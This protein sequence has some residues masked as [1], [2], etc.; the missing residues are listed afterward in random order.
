MALYIRRFI[1]YLCLSMFLALAVGPFTEVTLV[2]ET[3]VKKTVRTYYPGAGGGV[4]SGHYGTTDIDVPEKI[5]AP[6]KWFKKARFSFAFFL[7]SDYG[8]CGGFTRDCR[9]SA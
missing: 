6:I 9:G 1:V 3:V 4:I 8:P 7:S 2:K 5:T